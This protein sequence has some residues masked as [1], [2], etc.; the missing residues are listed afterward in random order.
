MKGIRLACLII[1]AIALGGIDHDNEARRS[2]MA[3]EDRTSRQLIIVLICGVI[4]GGAEVFRR[5]RRKVEKI[6]IDPRCVID[7]G[8]RHSGLGRV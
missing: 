6:V 2:G 5:Y 3:V 4:A 7:G 1:A 8:D